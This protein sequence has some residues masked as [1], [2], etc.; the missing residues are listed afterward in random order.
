[1]SGETGERWTWNPTDEQRVRTD[2]SG[3]H[4][5][6]NKMAAIPTCVYTL[7][8]WSLSIKNYL[9]YRHKMAFGLSGLRMLCALFDI[10]HI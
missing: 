2:C 4:T 3:C 10:S 9:M 8:T 6:K 7:Q 5:R 1:M